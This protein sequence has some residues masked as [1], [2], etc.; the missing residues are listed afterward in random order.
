VP[1]DRSRG[2]GPGL[3]RL[4]RV[5]RPLLRVTPVIPGRVQQRRRARAAAGNVCTCHTHPGTEIR[6]LLGHLGDS[7]NRALANDQDV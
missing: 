2:R 5:P 3:R 6:G 1:V 4:Q 7:G